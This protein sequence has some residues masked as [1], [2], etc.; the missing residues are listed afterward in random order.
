MN[1]HP[2][3]NVRITQPPVEPI[4]AEVV[5]VI[6]PKTGYYQS[7]GMVPAEAEEI[8]RAMAERGVAQA[9]I[10]H[11]YGEACVLVVERMQDGSFRWAPSYER[12]EV[13]IVSVEWKEFVQ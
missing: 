9:L 7:L 11:R 8:C 12:I 10:V 3:Q 13:E 6:E 2:G 5:E 4:F 1:F